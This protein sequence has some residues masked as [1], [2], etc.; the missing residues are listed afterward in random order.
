MRLN[1]PKL[2]LGCLIAF[3]SVFALSFA[4]LPPGPSLAQGAVVSGIVTDASGVPISNALVMLTSVSDS[5]EAST[6][7]GT[8]GSYSLQV[9]PDTYSLYFQW[10]PNAQSIVMGTGTITVTGDTTEDVSM[11]AIATL[12]VTV[13]D[14][15]NLPVQNASIAVGYSYTSGE[16]EDGTVI[17]WKYPGLGCGTDV[18]GQCSATTTALLGAT[19]SVQVTP[20]NGLAVEL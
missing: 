14:S 12:D 11:P 1:V 10:E 8:D 19:V 18:T 7:T 15:N 3:V 16:T 6:A 5:L 9:S 13:V 20:P 17:N 2:T 4:V